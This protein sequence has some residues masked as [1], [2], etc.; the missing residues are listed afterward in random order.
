M[1]LEWNTEQAMLQLVVQPGVKRVKALLAEGKQ[2]EAQ[3]IVAK[4]ILGLLMPY[5]EME[6]E[7]FQNTPDSLQSAPNVQRIKK[8]AEL[9]DEA[10]GILCDEEAQMLRPCE[11]WDLDAVGSLVDT[12][13]RSRKTEV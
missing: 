10:I 9:M 8:N 12:L 13:I 11:E 4:D 2:E 7:K 1:K 5:R 3:G 6:N